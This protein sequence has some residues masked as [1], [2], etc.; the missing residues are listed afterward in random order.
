MK[1]LL[2]SLALLPIANIA[3]AESPP[4]AGAETAPHHMR[5]SLMMGA[6]SGNYGTGVETALAFDLR[7]Q[8]LIVGAFGSLAYGGGSDYLLGLRLGYDFAPSD[9]ASL[10]LLAEGGMRSAHNRGGLLSGDPGV[11]VHEPFVGLRVAIDY[12]TNDLSDPVVFR[13]GLSAF[14]RVSFGSPQ[15]FTYSY[16][17]CLFT[18]GTETVTRDVG[19]VQ[20]F[21]ATLNLGLDFGR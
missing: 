7:L 9:D 15:T 8:P 18:C 20:E 14:G 11:S 10:D 16:E 19:G 2:A 3:Y 13:I 12:A 17:D 21:G 5:L 1:H 4:A 6:G